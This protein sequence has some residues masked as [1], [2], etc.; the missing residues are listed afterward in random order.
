VDTGKPAPTGT[1]LKGST[2]VASTQAPSEPSS[3][4]SVDVGQPQAGNNGAQTFAGIVS[5]TGSSSSAPNVNSPAPEAK[6]PAPE[7]TTAPDSLANVDTVKPEPGPTGTELKGSTNVASTQAASEFSPTK[8]TEEVQPLPSNVS[9]EPSSDLIPTSETV[10]QT[11]SR[12]SEETP[13]ISQDIKDLQRSDGAELV[14]TR[15]NVDFANQESPS[16]GVASEALIPAQPIADI[17]VND[18][19]QE[20]A[21]RDLEQ[22]GTL[23]QNQVA[24][25]LSSQDSGANITSSDWK[26]IQFLSDR[27]GFALTDYQRSNIANEQLPSDDTRSTLSSS[28]PL[29][30]GNSTLSTTEALI[31]PPSALD[32][33]LDMFDVQGRLDNI[34]FDGTE[35][36]L[37]IDS[38][39]KKS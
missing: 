36:P 19:A 3:T 34:T 25:V 30:T 20:T 10:A 2:N 24:L 17:T 8:A 15:N 6:S 18:A 13:Y 5:Q 23:T 27:Y 33:S 7:S 35:S 31:S 28:E 26:E 37:D 14:T 11:T 29:S 32:G 38:D 21:V 9:N 16:Q 39:V 4:K 22:R 1:E 12:S